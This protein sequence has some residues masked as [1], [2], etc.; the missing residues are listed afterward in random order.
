MKKFDEKKERIKDAGRKMF[1]AYGYHKTTLEDIASLMKLK[2]NS[3]YYYFP[4]KESLFIEL[5]EDEVAIYLKKQEKLLK[6][7]IP[8]SKKIIKVLNSLIQFIQ[9]RTVKYSIRIDSYLEM[10]KV[11]R[12][13]YPDFQNNQ[14]KLIESLLKEGIKSGEFKKHNTKLLSKD[15][16][17]LI[18][19]VFNNYYR[20][21]EAEFIYEIDLDSISKTVKRLISYIFDGIKK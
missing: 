13:H 5:I 14:C 12:E 7:D 9:Q 4:N 20:L 17:I 16:D 3:L 2:K 1:A 10:T 18:T 19:A 21:S 15:I 8:I 6:Q 11:L